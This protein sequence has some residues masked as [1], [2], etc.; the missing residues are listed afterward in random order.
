MSTTQVSFRAVSIT[1][2]LPH[3]DNFVTGGGSVEI[4]TT[5]VADAVSD[6]FN[7][8]RFSCAGSGPNGGSAL[9]T[10]H[11]NHL[12]QFTPQASGRLTAHAHF[13]ANG[14]FTLA[15]Q[16]S[17]PWVLDFLAGV[18]HFDIQATARVVVDAANGARVLD[19]QESRQLFSAFASGSSHATT[20]EGIVHVEAF[21]FH[22]DQSFPTQVTPTDRVS[23][24]AKYTVEAAVF[25][26]ASFSLDFSQKNLGDGLN[27][28]M[29]IINIS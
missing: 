11:A 9:F 8:V 14:G 5:P 10:L 4:V 18:A 17:N 22:I 23:V 24:F 26:G 1:H 7:N 16:A 21:E 25:E 28:P 29:A 15:A 19:A 13:M 12:F 6:A 2:S 20:N 3:A 27:S